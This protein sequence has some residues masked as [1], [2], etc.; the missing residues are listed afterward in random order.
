MT[1]PD[2]IAMMEH[3]QAVEMLERVTMDTITGA[4]IAG[5]SPS[6]IATAYEKAA[7]H[8]RDIDGIEAVGA[9][10]PQSGIG[11]RVGGRKCLLGAM[12][13]EEWLVEC[14]GGSVGEG[15]GGS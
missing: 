10:S 11:P 5:V 1:E 4:M 8:C 2:L 7:A 12:T 13:W 3:Q 15:L 9:I 6:E 14:G